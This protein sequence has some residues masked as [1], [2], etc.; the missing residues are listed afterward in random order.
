[1]SN[2]LSSVLIH[3]WHVHLDH[4]IQLL[5][6]TNLLNQKNQED[7]IED[8]EQ[9]EDGGHVDS[10]GVCCASA[11]SCGQAITTATTADTTIG[12]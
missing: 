3:C 8:A 2:T 7:R 11:V 4:V 9:N 12:I 1:M 6:A 10:I 5:D